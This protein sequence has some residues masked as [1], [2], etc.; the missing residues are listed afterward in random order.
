MQ[1][2]NQQGERSFSRGSL[3]SDPV[4]PRL[5]VSSSSLRALYPIKFK[6][7]YIFFIYRA[8]SLLQTRRKPPGW[9][10][11]EW[12]QPFPSTLQTSRG[13]TSGQSACSLSLCLSLQTCFI[14]CSLKICIS[15][16][17]PLLQHHHTHQR[18][19]P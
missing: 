18:M 2:G 8:R 6:L 5:V 7:L 16:L 4:I 11:S 1:A 17:S 14:F 12:Q 13:S 10:F 3:P 19:Y 9:N 15:V